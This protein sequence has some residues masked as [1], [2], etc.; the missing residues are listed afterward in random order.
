MFSTPSCCPEGRKHQLPK[1][2]IARKMCRVR[3]R[4]S[5]LHSGYLA[6]CRCDMNALALIKS[7]C[8]HGCKEMPSAL[9]RLLLFISSYFPLALV[10]F[11]LLFEC[12]LYLATVILVVGAIGLIGTFFYLHQAQRLSSHTV[13]VDQV[14][15]RDGE[16][17]SYIVTYL[18][19]F[20]GSPS[21]AGQSWLPL[22]SFS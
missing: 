14:E 1:R 10:S 6:C 21:M 19:P 12:Y 4:I 18:V 11:L 22:Q 15:R 16:A 7:H 17:M 8:P 2:S 5:L 13:A 3:V 20:S 9:V